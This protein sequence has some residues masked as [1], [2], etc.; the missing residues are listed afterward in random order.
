MAWL[1]NVPWQIRS[2]STCTTRSSGHP[3]DLLLRQAGQGHVSK[4]ASEVI[5][6]TVTRHWL[7]RGL[8]SVD[9]LWNLGL[10]QAG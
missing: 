10:A 8:L 1:C 4:A 6:A 3:Y 2:K 5:Q 9:G 7:R